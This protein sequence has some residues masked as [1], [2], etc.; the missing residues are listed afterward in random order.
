M[1][2]GSQNHI[3]RPD[4]DRSS[5]RHRFPRIQRQVSEDLPGLSGIHLRRPEIFGQ[6]E[7]TP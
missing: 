1:L 7:I 2:V 3:L 6:G 5:L 4:G